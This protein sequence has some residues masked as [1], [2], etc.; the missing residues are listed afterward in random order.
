M[1]PFFYFRVYLDKGKHIDPSNIKNDKL[2]IVRERKYP[3][4]NGIAFRCFNGIWHV[5][6]IFQQ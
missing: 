5:H 6:L 2:I 3:C 1:I 4:F